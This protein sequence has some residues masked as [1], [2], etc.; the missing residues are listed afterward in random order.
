LPETNYTLPLRVDTR[1]RHFHKTQGRRVIEFVVQLEIAVRNEWKPVIRYDTGH[2][3]AHIDRYNL[4]GNA[5]KE[6][7]PHSFSEAL[8][9][10]ERD[11]KQNWSIYRERF[12]KG[13]WP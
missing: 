3:F 4:R 2:G 12:L 6:R 5:Q 9:R 7:L 8:T 13:E 1:I 11:V 10:A